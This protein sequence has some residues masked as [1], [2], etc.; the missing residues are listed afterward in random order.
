MSPR[1][2]R[3]P[4]AED[5]RGA[6]LAAARAS[7]SERGYD[8][9]SVR[10]VARDAGVDPALVAHYFGTKDGLFTEALRVPVRPAQFVP[11]VLAGG[12]DGLGERV[13]RMFL[14]LWEDDPTRDAVLGMIRSAMSN[15]HA[16][17]LLRGFVTD[18][19]FGRI[20]DGLGVA[21][22]RLRATLVGAQ[23]VGVGMLRYVVRVEPIATMPVDELVDWLA[24]TLQR[25]LVGSGAGTPTT[26]SSEPPVS[27][28][29]R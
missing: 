27:K 8:A 9:T 19:L 17:E 20:A 2:G 12:V 4:A 21:D 5:T 23:L 11:Q 15:D 28:Q 16:A 29:V 13:A 22:A 6:I 24:P 1:T 18:A 14:S 25:Y 7:F 10:Q 3:R 26:A